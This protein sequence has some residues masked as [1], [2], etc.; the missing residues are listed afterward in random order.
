[1]INIGTGFGFGFWIDQG[2]GLAFVTDNNNALLTIVYK[3][4]ST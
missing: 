2:F 3:Y 4:N 1:V